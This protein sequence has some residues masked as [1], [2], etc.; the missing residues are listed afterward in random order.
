MQCSVPEAVTDTVTT[1]LS[2]VMANVAFAEQH[3][4]LPMSV[5]MR[6]MDELVENK[7]TTSPVTCDALDACASSPKEHISRIRVLRALNGESTPVFDDCIVKRASAIQAALARTDVGWAGVLPMDK[8]RDENV[9]AYTMLLAAG[10]DARLLPDPTSLCP[11]P[12]LLKA[13]QHLRSC[14][15][16]HRHLFASW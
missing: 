12:L 14:L 8:R 10:M 13:T 16:D 11:K 4:D 6:I 5:L 7:C 15:N 1:F 2:N 3:Q 9:A